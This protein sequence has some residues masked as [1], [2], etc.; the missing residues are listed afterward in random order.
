MSGEIKHTN[1]VR[2]E[3]LLIKSGGEYINHQ[4]QDCLP[5]KQTGL[6]SNSVGKSA[7]P[8]HIPNLGELWGLI[9]ME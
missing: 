7:Q 3:I 8:L 5:F 6:V 9:M 4:K 2:V 1:C